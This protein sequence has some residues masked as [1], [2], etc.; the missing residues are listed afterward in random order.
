VEDRWRD[1]LGLLGVAVREFRAARGGCS[2]GV[3]A[4][5]MVG[6]DVVDLDSWG[7]IIWEMRRIGNGP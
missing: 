6:V 5:P 3:G 2:Y 7:G 4:D 1:L